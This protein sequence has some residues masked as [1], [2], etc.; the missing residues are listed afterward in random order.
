MMQLPPVRLNSIT[1]AT[2]ADKGRIAICGS[3]GGLYPA[4]LAF[5]A[6]LG[7]VIF[8]DAGGGLDNAGIAG[9][10]ALGD[11]GMAAA[12]VSHMSCRIAD[13]DDM[14][15]RGVI[16]AVNEVAARAEV[17]VG[18]GAAS[19]A[20]KLGACPL[21]NGMA[22]KVEDTRR[23]IRA[24]G[25]AHDIVLVDS[26]SL[27]RPQDEGRI[28]ITGSHG[29]LIG[30][31]PAR[32]LK[33]EAA[34]AVFNDAG[35]GCD[36]AGTTRLPALDKRGIAAVTVSHVTA[37]IGEAMSAYQ[38]G[39]ISAANQAAVARGIGVGDILKTVLERA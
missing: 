22:A 33:A 29:G 34:L 8:N 35:G 11:I 18:E 23:V 4:Y 2:H 1:D 25:I 6:G 24:D 37:R 38:S 19:A 28:V 30:G 10:M 12:A 21:P 27:V 16:S 39:I 3:H 15:A 7:A 14:G 17:E 36:G 5:A 13:A 32:A 31:D 20:E 9:V 26:A